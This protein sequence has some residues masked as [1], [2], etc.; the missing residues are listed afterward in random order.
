MTFS[1]NNKKNV[2]NKREGITLLKGAIHFGSICSTVIL[3]PMQPTLSFDT[4]SA[5]WDVLIPFMILFNIIEKNQ[6]K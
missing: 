4:I 2:K 5:H 6:F 1:K 3:S